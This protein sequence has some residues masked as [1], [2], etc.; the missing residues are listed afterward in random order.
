M[1]QA[2][3]LAAGEGQRLRPFTVTRPKA[4]ISIAD[5]PIL[6]HIVESL[7]RCGIRDI[8]IVV[9]YRKTQ[10][11]DF[12]GSGEKF[13]VRISYES[14][15]KQLGTAHALCRVKDKVQDEFLVLPG[16]NLIEAATIADFIEVSPDAV[17]VKRVIDPQRYGVIDAVDDEVRSI[18]EKPVNAGSNLVNT[19]IY[20]FNKDIFK[21]AEDVL[22][23]PDAINH[24]IA[25]GRAVKA[26]ET[27][28]AWLDVIYPWDV[29]SLN[30]AIL[31]N[32]NSSVGGTIEDGVTLQ[33]K[34]IIGAGTVVRAGT[35]IYGPAVI[36][37]GCEIGPNVCIMPSTSIGDNVVISSFTQVKN[38]VIGDDV[39][40][41]PGSFV[42]DSAID[43]G[44][45]IKGR[46][47]ALGGP[48][49][50]RIG[51]EAPEISVGV[52]MGEDCAVEANVT[53]QPGAIIGNGCRI[54]ISRTIS[55]RLPDGSLVY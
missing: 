24:M 21:Y 11:L 19:G 16:D 31:Q 48:S 1:K 33:G 44:T 5:K 35:C 18:I 27:K 51:N 46:F 50:E 13:G 54:Q 39:T 38:S 34:V 20:A 43:K 9:G 52:I 29:I 23:I 14:Q 32:I 12:M 30:H 22:D 42:S 36:G 26:V 25:S 7:A 17:L 45:N 4:M 6:Q 41:G 37:D 40:L 55:G 53:A 15:D 47:T 49:G 2:V 10:V 3:I 28:G 8:I